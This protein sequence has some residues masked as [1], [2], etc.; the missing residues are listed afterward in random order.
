MK[1]KIEA[2]VAGRVSRI[3]VNQQKS[4]QTLCLHMQLFDQT[5]GVGPRGIPEQN[6]KSDPQSNS[7]QDSKRTKQ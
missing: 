2:G 1:R 3:A 4:T 7:Q 5:I 6:M